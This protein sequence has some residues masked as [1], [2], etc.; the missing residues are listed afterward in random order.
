MLL[1]T[2]C[3]TDKQTAVHLT[4]RGMWGSSSSSKKLRRKAENLFGEDQGRIKTKEQKTRVVS[5]GVSF[6]HSQKVEKI[7]NGASLRKVEEG[8]VTS[9]KA[10][11]GK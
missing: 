9:E 11:L 7:L 10:D 3:L 4:L 2:L 6:T 5:E 8:G 1:L